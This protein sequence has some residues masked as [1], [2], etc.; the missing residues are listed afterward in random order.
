MHLSEHFLYGQNDHSEA[1]ELPI[2]F[3][4]FIINYTFRHNKKKNLGGMTSN[5]I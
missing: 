1:M 3:C 4:T 5:R 2:G